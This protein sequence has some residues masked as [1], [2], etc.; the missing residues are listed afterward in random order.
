MVLPL[1][2]L[3]AAGAVGAGGATLGVIAAGLTKKEAS[4]TTSNT[5]TSQ[6]VYHAPYETYA[7]SIQYAPQSSYAYQGATTIINSPNSTANPKQAMSAASSPSNTPSW[8]I[9]QNYTPTNKT[10]NA[11]SAGLQGV[12]FTMIAIVGAVAV[13]GYALLRK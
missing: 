5:R 3:V 11:Q 10:D 1:L 6:D 13:I 9:P 2:P 12:D 7:P 8:Y 4:I